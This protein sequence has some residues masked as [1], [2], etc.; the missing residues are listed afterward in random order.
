MLSFLLME[1]VG[2]IHCLACGKCSVN[3]CYCQ[4]NIY[5]CQNIILSKYKRMSYA[6]LVYCLPTIDELC[7]LTKVRDHSYQ[8]E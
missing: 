3:V 5:N 2:L 1:A 4:V 8:N 6:H 7:V